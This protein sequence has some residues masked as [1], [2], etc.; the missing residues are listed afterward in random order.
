MASNDPWAGY[1]VQPPPAFPPPFRPPAPPPPKSHRKLIAL[2]VVIGVLGVACIGAAGFG[3]IR[4]VHSSSA[5]SGAQK[6]SAAVGG[7]SAYPSKSPATAAPHRPIGVTGKVPAGSKSSSIKLHEIRD[8]ERVCDKWYYRKSP[9][10]ATSVSPHP[11][12]I[13]TRDRKDLDFRSTTGIFSSD[14]DKPA[15]IRDAWE[16]KSAASVQLVA[17]VDLVTIG[18]KVKSCKIDKPKPSSIVMKEGTYRLS[19]YEVATRRK[20]FETKLVGEQET[21][22]LLILIGR[23]RAVYTGVEDAQ[24][25]DVLHRFVEE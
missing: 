19:L 25:E 14:Y 23:D 10:Y 4:A 5:A 1:G 17:C 7:P 20:L 22:P 16:P 18:S 9:K 6:G 3:A 2:L 24:L 11:I 21:C 13:S 15:R 12:V 8:L